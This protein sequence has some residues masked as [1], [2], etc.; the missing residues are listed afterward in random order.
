MSQVLTDDL[1][2]QIAD[3]QAI[4]I[5]GAG[6]SVGATNNAPVASWVGLLKDGIA[7]CEAV[8]RPP[9]GWADRYRAALDSGDLDE[10]LGLAEQVSRRLGYPQGGEWRRW[11]RETVGQ[12]KSAMN[13]SLEALRDLRVPI[14]TTNYDNLIEDATGWPAVTWRE[15]PLVERVLRGDDEGVLHLHGHWQDPDSV[16]LGIRSYEA[17]LGDAHAQTVLRSLRLRHR[18]QWL[19]GHPSGGAS[20]NRPRR[21]RCYRN[22]GCERRSA[23]LRGLSDRAV[24]SERCQSLRNGA[25]S[26]SEAGKWGI[27]DTLNLFG[28]WR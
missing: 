13:A 27:R 1:R 28:E 19:T 7:R 20:D 22:A 14:A 17:V 24:T 5:V 23:V 11:L 21:A 4:A 3:G 18:G 25:S 6:V 12:L 10:L 2:K 8:A 9:T 16:I 26:A 15:G